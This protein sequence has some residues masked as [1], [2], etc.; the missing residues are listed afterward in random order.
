MVE[1]KQNATVQNAMVEVKRKE[2][3]ENDQ[4]KDL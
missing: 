1:V 3:T 4:G 2:D